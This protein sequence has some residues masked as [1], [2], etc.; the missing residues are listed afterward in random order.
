MRADLVVYD[1]DGQI[2]LITE[3]KNKTGVTA[4]WAAKWR[5]NMLAH[6]RWPAAKFFMIA[7]P[8]R[9]YLWNES[10]RLSPELLAPAFEIDAVQL[11][12]PYIEA[13]EGSLLE[14]EISPQRFELAV[15][16]WLNSLLQRSFS[17]DQKP[18][19]AWLKDSGLSDAISG[20]RL[21]YEVPL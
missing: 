9:F 4:E 1:R 7:L 3:L 16:A 8:D 20:G 17:P 18:D 11:L 19:S 13:K 6:G 14:E 21:L 2:A 12:K 5:R 15:A 10:G